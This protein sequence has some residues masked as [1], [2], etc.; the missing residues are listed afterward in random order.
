MQHTH[1]SES[2]L[3]SKGPCDSCGSSDANA[4]YDDL[5]Q[6]CF[7]CGNTVQ[8]DGSGR[9]RDD[10]EH[11]GRPEGLLGGEFKTLAKRGIDEATCKKFDY[12]VG[13]DRDGNPV[14]V[15]T[16]YD[17]A[18]NPVAQKLRT[19]DKE[20]ACLGKMKQALLYGQQLWRS[21]G[22]KV[23]VTEGELDCLSVA[24]ALS[25]KWPVVSV[26]NGA[27]GA[28]KSL[29]A[30]LD[31]LSGFE[32]VCL[33]FDNDEP[34]RK[35][36]ED[37]AAI[38]PPG[39]VKFI[40]T[41]FELKDANDLLREHG[42]KAVVDAT[43]E[44]KDFRPDGI[45]GRDELTLERL[46]AP[47]TPG[48]QTPYPE[49]NALTKGIKPRQLW[50]LTAG[51]GVGK[52]TD[53]REWAHKA[54]IDG[55]KVGLIFLEESVVDTAKAL[56]AIDNN[57]LFSELRENN[58]IITPEQWRKSYARLIDH[59]RY[60]SYDHFGS[61]DSNNLINKVTY[62]AAQGCHQIYLDH[63]SIAVSGLDMEEGERRA[64]DKLMTDLRSI[65]ERYNTS[66]I[67]ISHLRKTGGQGRS[68]EEGGQISLDDLRG[69]GSLK[70][71]SDVVLAKERDQQGDDPDT[72]KLRLLKCRYTGRTGLADRLRYDTKTG[73]LKPLPREVDQMEVDE[74]DGDDA[75][76]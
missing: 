10:R 4:T 28:A 1:E 50:L 5:H 37:C 45:I 74:S 6:H 15:A 33:W 75:P 66:I 42:P 21:K 70:Q 19:P 36:V 73:R 40:T 47:E 72:S 59:G 44:A 23:I 27:Q 71:L 18:G 61:V 8:P 67:T 3:V 35:A 65:C 16:Y 38:L 46:M 49:L 22:K 64:I 55:L 53:A 9:P 29:A 2:N 24:Q 51:S 68:F 63:I 54:L 48:W 20:F 76:F 58:A 56:V 39:K 69:S 52:S 17:T 13:K 12:R 34:G 30:Q 32:E 25:L 31:W 41:P 11:A 43:W 62:L 26:P 14:Q 57:V 7:S 60:S